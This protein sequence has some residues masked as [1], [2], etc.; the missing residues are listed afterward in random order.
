V[1]RVIDALPGCR[2][3]CVYL[4]GEQQNGF[5]DLPPRGERFHVGLEC[6]QPASAFTGLRRARD[7]SQQIVRALSRL[8]EGYF[9][10][11]Q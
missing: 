11:R 2:V 9:N 7:L 8:E 1:G 10:A 5:S 4:R 6:L 3:L